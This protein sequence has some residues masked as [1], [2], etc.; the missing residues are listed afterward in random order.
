MFNYSF[1]S[2]LLLLFMLSTPVNAAKSLADNTPNEI[3]TVTAQRLAVSELLSPYS[4]SLIYEDEIMKKGIRTTV[5]ALATVPG[6]YL[7]KTAHGQGSPYIRGF[8]GFRNVFLIDGIRLNNAVFR[9][10]PNQYWNT[11]D[12]YS[13]AKFE[14]VKG[15]TSVVYGSDAIGG[16]V[17]A[18]TKLQTI[19]DFNT[20]PLVSLVY[21][22]ATAEQSN[23]MRA[24]FANKLSPNSALSV[25]FSA[26]DYGD[27]IAGG[28]INEQPNTS[29]DEFNF[30]VKWLLS[31][32]D[33]L[34]LSTAY[35]KTK[36][37]DVPRTHKTIHSISFSGTTV[38][39][40]LTRDLD[41]ERELLY[42]KLDA[43]QE[44]FFSDSAQFT[45][46][47]QKQ[48]EARNRLRTN[49]RTD[50]Q[51]FDVNTLGVN[52]NLL[53]QEGLHNIVYGLEY[54][55]DDVDSFSSENSIQGPVADNA[56]YQWLGIYGQNKYNV[57]D[58]TSIDFGTRWSYMRV[59]ANKIQDPFTGNQIAMK[60][61]WN[62]VVFNLRGNF[63]ITPKSSSVYIGISQGFRAPNLSDLTRFDSARSNEF[64]IPA[65]QLKP[66][67][68]LTF[69]SGVKF[70]SNNF[71]Y[72]ISIYYTRI[73]DQIQRI[74]TGNINRDG[75][76]E[77]T[78]KN[79]G[80]GYTYGSEIDINYSLTPELNVSA[81]M[82]Y[83]SGRVDTFPRSDNIMAREYISRLMPTNIN[84]AINYSAPSDDWWMHS[85]I[86]AYR[87]GDRLST[88]DRSDT[89]RIPPNGTP[90]F[91]ILDIGG[92]YTVSNSTQLTVNLHNILDKNYRV[93]GSGQNEA[94]VNL[95][96]SVEYQF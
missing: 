86:T 73:E 2:A 16:T 93:H 45:L 49:N 76:F 75:E 9:E 77:I 5:D 3:I 70:R 25:G 42:F 20:Q 54:Y 58:K 7:Q 32:S 87:A 8:T 68:Y 95:I 56:S 34:Q 82:A 72:D 96:A 74:P 92:G 67:H 44:T 84:L 80:N 85:S 18:I 59:N 11:I 36:Q 78:K 29:Y 27:L 79:I 91:T 39:N 35:F 69:D 4:T 55:R 88:R 40:E 33:D 17:N 50:Q 90:G 43:K 30:D 66:E 46:S 62:N 61:H 41:Q 94:G 15:T 14:V 47:Y 89:Q 21:R 60:N 6:V 22:G 63:Q 37:N 53:K 13:I 83:I 24:S 57:N 28:K 64:E 81:R 65:L 1:Y 52:L 26:K 48:S 31:I 23:V 10:G 51:G 38:G 12:A 19:D 71:N